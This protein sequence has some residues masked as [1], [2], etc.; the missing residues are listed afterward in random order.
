MYEIRETNRRGEDSEGWTGVE[1]ET[2]DDA[3]Y[4]C[5][6]ISD[7]GYEVPLEIIPWDG[8]VAVDTL[9]GFDRRGAPIWEAARQAA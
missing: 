1:A 7:E 2:L 9:V 8:D 3:R 6:V 4:A 5:V